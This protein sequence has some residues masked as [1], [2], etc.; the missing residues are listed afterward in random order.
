MQLKMSS[1]S[2]TFKLDNLGGNL[3]DGI[4]LIRLA[5]IWTRCDLMAGAVVPASNKVDNLKNLTLAAEAFKVGGLDC[6]QHELK[7]I[8]EGSHDHT[9][10]GSMR[11]QV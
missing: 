7:M 4:F 2:F 8:V 6:S 9:I 5:E 11:S 1:D 3:C 10:N